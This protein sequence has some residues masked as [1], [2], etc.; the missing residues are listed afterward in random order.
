MS[1]N[2]AAEGAKRNPCPVDI[3][4]AARPNNIKDV[5]IMLK[6]I[7]DGVKT[8][9]TNSEEHRKD[10]LV[11]CRA[12][13]QALE[14]PRETMVNHCWGQIGAMSAIS[15]GVECG[16]WVLMAQNGDESQKVADL[17]MS[18]GVDPELLRRPMRHM[19]AMG[20]LLEV[21]E[22][23]Y[24]PTN[25]T[26]ALS[27]PQIGHGYLGLAATLRF[28]EFSR[29]TGWRN[30]TDHLSTSLMCAYGTNKDVFSWV[31]DM[32]YGRH[33]NDY[34]GGYSLGRTLWMDTDVYPV[35]QRLI[36]GADTRPDAPFLVDIGGNVGHD[37]ER[38]H[39][40]YPN[41]PGKLILQDLPIMIE[42]IDVLHP[43]IVRMKY[44]F[45]QEQP[46]KG[47]RAYYI[48]ST[49]HNWPDSV[50]DSILANVK[51]AMKQGY[52]K[53]L[54]NENVLPVTGAHWE[55]TGLDMM[56]LTLFSSQERTEKM[57]YDLIENR[58][59]LKI[60]K[61]WSGGKGVESVIECELP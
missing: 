35:Q 12:L 14:T 11:R 6:S 49:L 38:F 15:F 41:A 57:W 46:I 24:K 30:P 4:I 8:I 22:D 52:S 39:N 31:H 20:L 40:R 47:A 3:S 25:Y 1:T 34:L 2:K 29:K 56:M 9:A 28:H 21:G 45:H 53:L 13:V 16:L 26:R 36:E 51:A 61:I 55:T 5:P 18:L 27:L 7:E 17:A 37:L 42:Q 32:G 50:C 10:L 23:E 44:D 59:S 54:I 43:A 58:A 33:L 48:H 60:V 19:G